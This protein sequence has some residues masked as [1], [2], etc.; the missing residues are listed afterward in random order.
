MTVR[1]DIW[2]IF[3]GQTLDEIYGW[4]SLNSLQLKFGWLQI[5]RDSLHPQYHDKSPLITGIG[6]QNCITHAVVA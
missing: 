6:R 5:M 2:G 4:F 1:F 3:W